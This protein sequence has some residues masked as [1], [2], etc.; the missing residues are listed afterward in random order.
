LAESFLILVSLCLLATEPG[1]AA[2]EPRGEPRKVV[3]GVDGD[4]L[5]LDGGEKVRVTG[6]R[7]HHPTRSRSGPLETE[8]RRTGPSESGR[9]L[10]L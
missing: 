2:E 5:V 1:S 7:S 4:T 9:P 3:R 10:S 6:S 8:A